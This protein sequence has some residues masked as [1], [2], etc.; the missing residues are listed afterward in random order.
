M[1]PRAAQTSLVVKDLITDIFPPFVPKLKQNCFNYKTVLREIT[2][3]FAKANRTLKTGPKAAHTGL[4][5]S[6]PLALEIRHLAAKV[7]VTGTNLKRW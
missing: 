4:E 7:T 2:Y 5:E 3:L 1:P 6:P